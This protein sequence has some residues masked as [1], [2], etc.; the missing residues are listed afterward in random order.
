M[1]RAAKAEDQVTRYTYRQNLRTSQGIAR[2]YGDDRLRPRL[3]QPVRQTLL[4]QATGQREL[5]LK[6]RQGYFKISRSG[7]PST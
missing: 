7:G 1:E 4:G 5:D 2:A 3:L 6:A